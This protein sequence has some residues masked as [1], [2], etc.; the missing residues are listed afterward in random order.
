MTAGVMNVVWEIGRRGRGGAQA[1][2]CNANPSEGFGTE[3]RESDLVSFFVRCG[4]HRPK[5]SIQKLGNNRQSPLGN[6]AL[7]LR[8]AASGKHVN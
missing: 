5:M 7:F 8:L 3:G 1:G 4:T 2:K 6:V